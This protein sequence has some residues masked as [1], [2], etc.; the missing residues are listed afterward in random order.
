MLGNRHS[1]RR[2]GS[3]NTY[4]GGASSLWRSLSIARRKVA[5]PSTL[6]ASPTLTESAG[7]VTSEVLP[8]YLPSPNFD[9]TAAQ[10]RG[11]EHGAS[12]GDLG[13]VNVPLSPPLPPPLHTRGEAVEPDNSRMREL[14]GV[15]EAV[16]HA[17]GNVRRV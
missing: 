4:N 17:L 13:F 14:R 16:S 9:G 5:T 12:T 1:V 3:T 11:F 6:L 8:S 10:G 7:S 2:S 15:Y